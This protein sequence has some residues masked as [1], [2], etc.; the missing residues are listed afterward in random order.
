LRSVVHIHRFTGEIVKSDSWK[1]AESND[2]RLHLDNVANL[3]M[4]LAE[5]KKQE[6]LEAAEKAQEKAA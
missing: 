3:K 2:G 5:L 6:E 4:A 1:E